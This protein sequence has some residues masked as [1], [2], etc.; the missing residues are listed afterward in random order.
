MYSTCIGIN[1]IEYVWKYTFATMLDKALQSALEKRKNENALRSLKPSEGLVD[2][3]SNDYLGF[4]KRLK[5]SNNQYGSTGSRLI[6]GHHQ[7]HDEVE[8]HVAAFH[9][10]ES[11]LIFNSGYDANLGFFSTVPSKCDTVIYDKLCHASIRDGLRLGVA[12]SFSFKHNDLEELKQ[13]LSKAEGNIF[14]VVESV[15]SMDGDSAPLKQ[16]E[17]IC[18]NH[19]A[20]LVVDEA[21]ATGVFGHKGEGLCAEIGVEPYAR[22]HTFGK[23]LGCHGAAVCGSQVLKDYLINFARS[24]IYTTALPP[25]NLEVIKQAYSE[26]AGCE[27]KMY[28]K[29]NIEFF[30]FQFQ[31]PTLIESNSPIQCIVLGDNIKC[32]NVASSLQTAG[33]D[34]RPILSPTVEKGKE[35]IR[36]CLHSFNSRDEIAHLCSQLNELI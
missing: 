34:I 12:R 8:S 26:L 16:I 7:I 35:R 17:E 25:H 2:F 10:V 19:K 22:V 11:A 32:K 9:N 29:K 4:S 3:C 23:A 21:H 6:A 20:N 24:F 27:E 36:I 15:Y 1:T 14:V 33:L 30:K 18:F 28:L 31:S 13:K 5:T